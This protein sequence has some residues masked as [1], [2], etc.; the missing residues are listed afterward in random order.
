VSLRKKILLLAAKI[1]GFAVVLVW[2]MGFLIMGFHSIDKLP[3][4]IEGPDVVTPGL[5]TT[6]Y[7]VWML[8]TIIII[9]VW[10]SVKAFK[11][12]GK[13][14]PLNKEEEEVE[15]IPLRTSKPRRYKNGPKS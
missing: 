4:F 13:W 5:P 9:G 8:I 1:V 3:A 6:L 7:G 15:E 14:E 10:I 12:I 2:I 11:L